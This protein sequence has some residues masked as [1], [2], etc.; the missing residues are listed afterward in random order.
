MKKQAKVLFLLTLL[1]I[2]FLPSLAEAN[3]L[4]GYGDQQGFVYDLQHR[5]NQLGYFTGRQDGRFGKETYQ[6]VL[7]FQKDYG[8]KADGLVG[9]KT[10]RALYS[11]TFTEEEIQLLTRVVHA[12]ANGEPYAGQV[13]VAA[14]I[15]NR[16]ESPD[17]PKSIKGI[18]FEPYAFESVA[19]GTIWQTP[20]ATARRAVYDA[21]R[22]Y[23]PTHGA[24]F[25]FNPATAKSKWMWS[26]KPLATIG[27]HIFAA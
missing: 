19:N 11:R 9:D 13:A 4:L 26:R 2:T 16:L 17:F 20:D 18:I 23:D 12:E 14:V 6:A 22:G 7:R 25:F 3:P 21:I 24:L 27:H 10:W 15:L 5:L 8:L 1:L